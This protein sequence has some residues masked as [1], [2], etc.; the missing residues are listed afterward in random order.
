MK[1]LF[2]GDVVGRSGRDVIKNYI[3]SLKS[4]L[5]LDFIIINGENSAH[6]FG[7]TDKICEDIFSLGVDVITLGNHSFDNKNI[8][9]YIV[10][11]PNLIRPLNYKNSEGNGFCILEC[12]NLKIMV[13]NLLGTLFMNS[14]IQ[15]SNPFECINSLLKEYKLKENIDVIIVDFHSETTSEKNSMGLFLDG[16]VSGV[17]GTHTHIPTNDIRILPKGTAYQTDVGMCGDYNSVIGM[18]KDVAIGAFFL[19]EGQKKER[20]SPASN[21]GML[22]GVIMEIDDLTGKCIY[23]KSAIYGNVFNRG[24]KK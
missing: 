24:N 10:K 19:K 5:N 12:S 4:S 23:I 13:V 11:T 17:F 9:G 3:P 16:R 6:G 22:S 7:I 2:C 14:K 15:L 8:I 18:D 21:Q 20:L 1:I